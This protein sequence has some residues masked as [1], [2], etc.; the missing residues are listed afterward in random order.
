MSRFKKWSRR[1]L[2]GPNFRQ[3]SSF[4]S[5]FLVY[6]LVSVLVLAVGGALA[7]T[8]FLFYLTQDL[9]TPE[10]LTNINIAESTNIYDREGKL[11]Y[12]IHGDERRNV[13]PLRDISP[14]LV[15][16]T[17]AVEDDEFY[18]HSGF[19]WKGILRAAF[20]DVWRKITG[21]ANL[22]GGSTITQ[23]FVKNAFLSKEKT[24]IR[25]LKELI[26]ALQL[27][28]NFTKDE[29]LAL[30]FNQISYGANI[31]GA[32]AASKAFFAKDAKDL[33]LAE[34]ATLAAIP[35]AP[36]YFSP[37]G[38]NAADLMARKN[39]VLERLV[40][41]N[42]ITA[43]ELAPAKQEALIFQ[44][45]REDITAPHFVFY[46]RQLLE[47][48]FGKEFLAHGGLKVTT[49]LSGQLQDLAEAVIKEKVEQNRKL[50]NAT[51]A[52]LVAINPKNGEIL[53]MVGSYNFFEQEYDGQVNVTLAKRQ[54]GSAFKPF[55]YAMGFMKGYSPATVV[56]DVLTDFSATDE[57]YAPN[58][59]T[60]EFKGPLTLRSAL[61]ESI[62][63]PAVKILHLAG[64]N[65]VLNLVANLGITTLNDPGRYG[66]SLVLGGG[67]VKLM[68]MV[69]AYG[70]FATGG[71]FHEINP[72][73]SIEDK[74]GNLV[75]QRSDD[76]GKQV[77]PDQIAYLINDILSDNQARTPTF[78][79]NNSLYLASHKVAAKT[80]T[81]NGF[82]DAWTIGY[83][84]SLVA[85]VWVG[86]N[87]NGA[88][89]EKAD[90]S[91]VAAPIWQ[92][93]M[94]AALKDEPN[95]D[96]SRPESIVTATVST[97][98]GLLPS[99]YTPASRRRNEIFAAD[100]N[101]PTQTSTAI[102]TATI[103]VPTKKLANRYCPDYLKQTL[104]Y[105]NLHSLLPTRFEWEEPVQ[106]WLKENHFLKEEE[107]GTRIAFV[108]NQAEIPT[109]IDN[110]FNATTLSSIP[111][112]RFI[113]P[114]AGSMVS[115]G[116]TIVRFETE[117]PNG[118]KGIK[119]YLGP[120]FRGVVNSP[121][122]KEFRLEIIPGLEAKEQQLRAVI[123]DELGL[124]GETSM[125]LILV[126]DPDQSPV[127]I[128]HE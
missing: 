88:M 55:V 82:R 101:V 15:S 44:P 21:K 103:C 119:F 59:Y 87:D 116:S 1:K 58:N 3:K 43:T 6:S 100:Y 32:Q 128:K 83:T 84:P 91:V 27:E 126:A 9:P 89:K 5:K 60:G 4:L 79:W 86:N 47:E 121:D 113:S 10:E 97:L 75:Y 18:L 71:T 20:Y 112:I 114:P 98:D 50:W 28:K 29:I 8:I 25:K 120:A 122:Q 80:G 76:E 104:V 63:I 56:F 118:F 106:T 115:F 90:G 72:I 124:Q 22:Q 38:D 65:N 93:F 108:N 16:A 85:G 74:D 11:L 45:Y 52:G 26:L 96:F 78:G 111:K 24:I 73:L 30:Y 102:Q 64:V 42:K 7:A 31:Y 37:Y 57:P 39:Y 35:K 109:D 81:T 107:F 105:L 46:V 67:E 41:L 69:G 34:A 66:L 23:Q 54:P 123:T 117:T 13:I 125:P 61:A 48:K 110:I 127:A 62:N 2:K 49:S 53:A 92:K 36:T 51:N 70:V 99:T 17:L 40:K 68:E 12:E 14:Y 33:S 95:E 19:D 94:Q 77:M